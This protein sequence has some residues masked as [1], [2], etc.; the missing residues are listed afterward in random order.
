MSFVFIFHSQRK[1][2]FKEWEGGYYFVCQ[3]EQQ[4]IAMKVM[5]LA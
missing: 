2:F 5:H 1:E 3:K 4:E